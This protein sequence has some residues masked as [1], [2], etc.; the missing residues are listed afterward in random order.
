MK[1]YEIIFFYGGLYTGDLTS[2]KTVFLNANN[3]HEALKMFSENY[4]Y[5]IIKSI[6]EADGSKF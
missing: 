5:E 6:T 4:R 3:E 2:Q 1:N